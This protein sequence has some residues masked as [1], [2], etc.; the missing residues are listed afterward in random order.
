MYVVNLKPHV[1]AHMYIF[2]LTEQR[3]AIVKQYSYGTEEEKALLIR[4]YGR[5]LLEACSADQYTREWIEQNSKK[6][7]SCNTPIQVRV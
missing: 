1:D 4:R 3:D 2:V 7:P 6:C 5:P